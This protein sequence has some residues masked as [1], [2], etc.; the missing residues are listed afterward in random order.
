M[1][2]KVNLKKKEAGYELCSVA[3]FKIGNLIDGE[4]YMVS[5][6]IVEYLYDRLDYVLME[7]RVDASYKHYGIDNTMTQMVNAVEIAAVAADHG[8]NFTDALSAVPDYDYADEC[9]EPQPSTLDMYASHDTKAKV[10][11]LQNRLSMS[12]F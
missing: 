11:K 6:K 1:S 7:K 4:S 2:S 5:N 8:D 12:Y 3:G 9:I 10:E